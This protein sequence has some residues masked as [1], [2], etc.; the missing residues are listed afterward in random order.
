MF[1]DDSVAGK[2]PILL[3][4]VLQQTLEEKLPVFAR[5]LQQALN[6]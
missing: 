5:R 2:K 1:R 4:E 6:D 3:A